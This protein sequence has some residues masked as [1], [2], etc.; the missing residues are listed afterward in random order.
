MHPAL[1]VI[2]LTTLI[3][4]GQGLFLAL[5]T[6]QV[7]AT[8]DLLPVQAG[9]F[10]AE[11]S[12][13]AALFLIGGL[14]ASFFHLG[15]PERAWRSAAMWRTSWLSREVIVLPALIGATLAYA[16]VHWL[17]W[18]LKIVGIDTPLPGDLSLGI[19]AFGVLFAFGLFLCTG[20][21]YACIK[22]LQ[23]WASWLTVVNYTLF[24]LASGFLFA[25]AFAAYRSPELVNFFGIWTIIFTAAAL[26]T[27]AASLIRN[28][29]IKHKSS[30]Q[31]AI[32]VRHAQVTQRS[33]G[34]MGGS[35]NTREFFHGAPVAVF[36]AIK[37]VFLVLVFPVPMILLW[38]GIAQGSAPIILAAFAV[39]YL[40]LMAERWFFFAQANHPQNLYYQV[41]S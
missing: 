25:T 32:G 1:S 21:I 23:E 19:G 7:Y 11:G 9:S 8:L 24:G 13:L 34:F 35:F 28:A 39:Q 18:D 26:V 31:T 20:M 5:Y 12:A 30:L 3:G 16:L 41:V 10:Y 29:R 17:G 4:V 37:W 38:A 40:G 14:L 33:Q 2:F 36:R 15:H 27:R 22:F 6:V